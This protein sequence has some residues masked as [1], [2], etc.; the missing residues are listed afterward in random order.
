MKKLLLGL[1]L[2]VLFLYSQVGVIESVNA[3]HNSAWWFIIGLIL[4]CISVTNLAVSILT[5]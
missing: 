5:I 4:V 1:S 3:H 2:V